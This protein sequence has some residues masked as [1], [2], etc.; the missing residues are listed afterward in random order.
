[1]I[2]NIYSIQDTLIGFSDPYIMVNEE[3]AKR[4]YHNFLKRNPNAPDMRLFKIGTFDDKTGTI[5]SIIPECIEGG[6][7]NG[8]DKI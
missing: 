6:G 3:V 8:E 7:I 1:M 4:E 2:K 5:I